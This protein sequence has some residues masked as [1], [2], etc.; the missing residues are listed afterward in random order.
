M[1]VICFSYSKPYGKQRIKITEKRA[2][3]KMPG[4]KKQE[5]FIMQINVTAEELR[6]TAT[7]IRNLAEDY[8]TLYASN[9]LN[10]NLGE[11]KDAWYGEDQT[12]YT[13][14]VEGFK[15]NF[16]EM[17]QL[18]LEYAD[19]LTKAANEYDRNQDDL[20]ARGATL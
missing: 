3:P 9:L 4:S 10:S 1:N 20:T 16:D 11:L 6:N 14:K 13:Q 5:D 8:R 12:S 19:H 15:A 2:F 18:M 17:Y 7:K